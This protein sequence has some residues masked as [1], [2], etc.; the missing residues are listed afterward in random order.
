MAR[1]KY[2]TPEQRKKEVNELA[3]MN[4]EK[5]NNYFDSPENLKEYFDF[6]ANMNFY[7][8]STRNSILIQ[9][10]FIGAKAVGSFKFW[11]DKGFPV[12]KG[13]KGIKILA[14][15]IYKTFDREKNGNKVT[16]PVKYA[17][18]DEKEKINRGDIA[19]KENLSYT[20]GHVFDISQTKATQK[21]LPQIFPN[22]W[23]DGSVENYEA[24]RQSLENLSK[25]MGVEI[26]DKP[27]R[28]ELG[29]SKGAYVEYSQ[30]NANGEMEKKKGIELNPRNGELQNVK[31]LVHELAHAKLH[32]SETENSKKLN[33]SEMEFQAEMTAYTVCSYFN[34]DTSD[35]SLRYLDQY[36]NN[37][38]D[39]NDRIALLDEVKQTS[40]E[41]TSHI[42]KDLL[43]EKSFDYSVENSMENELSDL[44]DKYNDVQIIVDDKITS[45]SSLSEEQFDHYFSDE[46]GRNILEQYE[47]MEKDEVIKNFN[48]LGLE[49]GVD[50]NVK[51]VDGHLKEPH[52][53]VVWSE[54]KTDNRLMPVQEMDKMLAK[55]NLSSF[56]HSNYDKTRV[57]LVVPNDGK[58]S[59][60]QLDRIDLGDGHH[61][62]LS[63]HLKETN[64]NLL[65][66]L[67]KDNNHLNEVYN[68]NTISETIKGIYN[69]NLQLENSPNTDELEMEVA[70]GKLTQLESFAKENIGMNQSK[71]DELKGQVYTDFTYRND[72]KNTFNEMVN[73]QGSYKKYQEYLKEEN[74]GSLSEEKIVN[75]M[76]AENSYLK[77]RED[78]IE[79]GNIDEGTIEKMEKFVTKDSKTITDEKKKEKVLPF[80]KKGIKSNEY[81]LNM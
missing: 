59:V 11:K 69:K 31:T 37:H 30:V 65:K 39:I 50:T 55:E 27:L 71:I 58:V 20:V 26:L 14:P 13:E 76:K 66:H 12:E 44:K 41:F 42:E 18:S 36:T 19:V 33:H 48:N 4:N 3:T 25:D 45:I 78:A 67:P 79:S 74:K 63:N 64:P 43:L 15:Y 80:Q 5:V 81:G 75:R 10:Q 51:M 16:T 68:E 1:K 32:N 62:S 53:F 57:N 47:G 2:K 73:L 61:T 9:N 54:A 8:Y 56:V 60:H 24:M 35:Y 17:T 21:D 46:H 40:Y 70:K 6:M 49:K 28:E 29:A 34:I 77:Q 22:K 23:L 72:Y 38:E 7:D 52:A